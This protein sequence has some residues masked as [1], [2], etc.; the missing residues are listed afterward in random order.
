MKSVTLNGVD[1]TD[2]PFEAKAS[3]NVTGLEIILTDQQTTLSGTVKNSRGEPVKDFVVA[4]FPAA[5]RD[6]ALP[7]RFTRT[8]RPDQEGRYQIRALPPGDYVAVALESLEQGREWDP[9][10]QQIVKP[11]GKAFR[12]NDAQAVTLDLALIQ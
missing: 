8:I 5:L 3:T 6:G 9:A 10:F 2:T 7:T 12:L 1:I 4:I 11:R